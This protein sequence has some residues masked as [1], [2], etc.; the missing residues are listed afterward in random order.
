VADD[1]YAPLAAAEA[2]LE[3]YRAPVGPRE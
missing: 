3:L 1:P 2:L